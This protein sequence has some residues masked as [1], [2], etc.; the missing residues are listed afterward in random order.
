MTVFD[1]EGIERLAEF[2]AL[3]IQRKRA[4][5]RLK[6]ANERLASAQ[7]IAHL[8]SWEDYL[9]TGELTWSEEM[10]NIMGFPP[11]APLNLDTVVRGFP[12]E[13]LE[14]FQHDVNAA[15]TGGSS[16]VRNVRHLF[17]FR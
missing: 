17:T 4:E 10:Y 6:K 16:S 9:P 14:R 12:I 15:I 2:Y 8:G 7:R 13:D 5:Q 3:A 1:R 11:G